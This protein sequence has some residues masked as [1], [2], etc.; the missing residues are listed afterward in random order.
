M[1][2]VINKVKM[3]ADDDIL[4]IDDGSTDRSKSILK[5]IPGIR[6]L[7]QDQNRGYGSALIQGFAYGMENGYDVVLT[8][9]CDDQHEPHLIPKFLEKIQG[10]D[11]V[12]GSRYLNPVPKELPPPESRKGINQ[13]IT[14]AINQITSFGLTDAFCGF[15]A[16]KSEALKRLDLD[17]KG[18]AFPLQLWIEAFAADLSLM[19][20]PVGLIYK[21]YNRSFGEKLDDPTHRLRYYEEVIQKALSKIDSPVGVM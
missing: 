15:K 10:V 18:Y 1:D 20:I 4:A 5:K 14:K 6:V 9:D 3:Y 2:D 12:S 7:D 19:E 8:M 21:N 13:K 16:Y 11:I 17:E